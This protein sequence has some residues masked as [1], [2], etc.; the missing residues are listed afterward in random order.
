MTDAITHFASRLAFETD[1]ADVAAALAAGEQVTLI[2]A[3]S[4]AAYAQGHLPGAHNLPRP[5]TA[6]A[7]A[8]LPPGELVTYCWGPGCNGATK[9]ALELARLGRPVREMIGGYEYWQ[10]EGH[11][12]ITP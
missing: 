6:E 4:P 10:R 11:P 12:V 1:P 7:V 2:D 5:F 3:R 9:A 8:A